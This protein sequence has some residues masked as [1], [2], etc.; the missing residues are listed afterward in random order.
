MNCGICSFSN[1]MNGDN[2]M[3][4]YRWATGC[5]LRIFRHEDVPYAYHT[6]GRER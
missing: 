3:E 1:G 4:I 5:L 6:E 2:F